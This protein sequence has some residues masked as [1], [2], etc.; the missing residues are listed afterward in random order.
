SMSRIG[1]KPI[2]LKGAEFSINA[3]NV[4]TLKGDK[5][6]DSLKID[7]HIKVEQKDGQLH[8]SRSSDERQD[9]SLHGLYRSLISNMVYGVKEGYNKEMEII[10]IGFRASYSGGILELSLGFSHPVY[11]VPP[12]EINIEVD[13]KKRKNPTVIVS[14]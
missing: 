14:G 3:D 13:R 2:E 6:S 12:E 5:G 4:I 9:R 1:I 7:R 11:F 10:G 8:V